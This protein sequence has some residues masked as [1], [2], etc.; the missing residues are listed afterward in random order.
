MVTCH[1]TAKKCCETFPDCCE[2]FQ[3]PHLLS[4]DGGPHNMHWLRNDFKLIRFERVVDIFRSNYWCEKKDI[5]HQ[6]MGK[7]DTKS[8]PCP[9]VTIKICLTHGIYNSIDLS[10]YFNWSISECNLSILFQIV[11]VIWFLSGLT[12]KAS[13]NEFTSLWLSF[14]SF[15]LFKLS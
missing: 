12:V 9:F 14:V 3:K 5:F 11:Y 8:I 1:F 6:I 4:N 10:E 15:E 2:T 7:F 13:G